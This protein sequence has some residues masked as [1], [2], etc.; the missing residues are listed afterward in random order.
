MTSSRMSDKSITVGIVTSYSAYQPAGLERFLIDWLRALDTYSSSD[1]TY[2]VYTKHGSGLPQSL[3]EEG[4]E[5]ITVI[6][7]A[8]GIFWKELG[9]FFVPKADMYIFNG[10]LVPYLFFPQRYAV[11]IYDF[12]YQYFGVESWKKK[13]ER[14]YTNTCTRISFRRAKKIISISN[15]T[16]LEAQKFFH[17]TKEKFTTIYPGL[18]KFCCEKNTPVPAVVDRPFFLFVGTLKE[19]KNVRRVIEAYTIFRNNNPSYDHRLCIVGKISKNSAYVQ[20]LL[21]CAAAS[22]YTADILFLGHVSDSQLA[23][24]YAHTH[25]LVFPSLLEGFGF[26]VIEAMSIKTLVITSYTSSLSEVAGDAAI[27]VNPYSPTDI[28]NG[29]VRSLDPVVKNSCI[30]KG[31]TRAMCFSWEQSARDMHSFC[32]DFFDL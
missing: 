11:L 6:E 21:S 23:Y 24:L 9:L 15:F 18:T 19:R 4:I 10:S 25:A 14:W 5:R 32:R 22:P 8:G 16:S 20:S 3:K 17:V 1:I 12:A 2:I 26:P 27:L 30:E 28:A 29:L 13:L 31:L 7:V